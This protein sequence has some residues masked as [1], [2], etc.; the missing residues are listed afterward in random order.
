MSQILFA[1][2]I[3]PIPEGMIGA[4]VAPSWSKFASAASTILKPLKTCKQLLPNVWLLPA[5]NA[6]PF[7]LD[8][9]S[10][11]ENCTLPYVALL[12]DDVTELTGKLSSGMQRIP[13]AGV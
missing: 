12:I 1:V 7:L 10:K 8:L 2:E 3:P 9:S 5:E 6:L 4:T 13:L 11:A